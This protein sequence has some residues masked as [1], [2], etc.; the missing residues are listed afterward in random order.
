MKKVIDAIF[1]VIIVG[2]IWGLY[3]FLGFEKTVITILASEVYRRMKKEVDKR[4][5]QD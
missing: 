4:G 3:L 2:S 1:F 5:R